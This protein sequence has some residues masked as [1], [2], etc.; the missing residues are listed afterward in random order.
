MGLQ[1]EDSPPL[2]A[3]PV[4]SVTAA[5]AHQ[6][7]ELSNKAG[8]KLAAYPDKPPPELSAHAK[9]QK[10]HKK[11]Q[12]PESRAE[13]DLRRLTKAKEQVV[14]LENSLRETRDQLKLANEEHKSALAKLQA[15]KDQPL[16]QQASLKICDL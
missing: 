10:A 8:D 6:L 15:E 2:P 7:S 16:S 11:A 4:P 9:M 5:E 14:V 13:K 3:G 12:Q 1:V